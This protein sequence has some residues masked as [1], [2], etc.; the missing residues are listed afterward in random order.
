MRDGRLTL[1][2]RNKLLSSM[3]SEVVELVLRNNYLQSLAISLESR[4]GM[5]MM[6]NFA[7]LMKFLGKEGA[8]DRELEHLPSVVS[9]EERIRE[10]VSLSR[11]EIAILLAYAKLK[12]SEQLL[13]STLIDDPFFFNILLSYFPRQFRR[14]IFRRYSE[15]SIT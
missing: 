9:F 7:Q 15:S 13:D 2:N 5:A 14:V 6:W 1:E 12:L 8:L 3:T 4:K 11:P 10:E